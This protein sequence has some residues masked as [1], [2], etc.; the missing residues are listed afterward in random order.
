MNDE[1]ADFDNAS[2]LV[3]LGGGSNTSRVTKDNHLLLNAMAASSKHRSEDMKNVTA[4][5]ADAF[6]STFEGNGDGMAQ[7]NW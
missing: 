3:H 1:D 4:R 5:M 7:T 6:K 2:A